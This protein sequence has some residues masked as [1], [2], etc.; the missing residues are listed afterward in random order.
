M[1][2]F[3]SLYNHLLETPYSNASAFLKNWNVAEPQES[4]FRLF[5][6]LGIVDELTDFNPCS[7]NFNMKTVRVVKTEADYRLLFQK[8]LRDK[9]DASDLTMIRGSEILATTSKN[10]KDYRVGDLDIDRIYCE[11][12]KYE[13]Y[14]LTLCIVIPDKKEFYK[15]VNRAEL[16]S[17]T[18]VEYCRRAIVLDHEDLNRYLATF[19]KEFAECKG[20]PDFYSERR[21]MKLYFHQQLAVDRFFE[22]DQPK[23]LLGCVPRSGKS[24]IVAGIIAKLNQ[25]DFMIMTTCPNETI[26]QYVEIFATYS[27]FR[28]FSVHILNKTKPKLGPKNIFICSQQYMK[29]E[30]TGRIKNIKWLASRQL[31]IIFS[32]EA[33]NGGTT[34]TSGKILEKYGNGKIMYITATY[35]KPVQ[36]FDIP[37]NAQILW[38]L[39]DIRLCKTNPNKL[40]EK[41][42]A[43]PTNP[44]EYAKYPDF[45]IMTV[46]FEKAIE[47]ELQKESV[48]GWSTKGVFLLKQNYKNTIGEFQDPD[49]VKALCYSIFG[50]RGIMSRIRNIVNNPE[51]NSRWF[52]KEQPLIVMC[53][54]PSNGNI[55]L[56]MKTFKRFL[57]EV[58][59]EFEIDY[60]NSKRSADPLKVIEDAYAL[61]K[62]NRKKGLIVLSGTQCSLGVSIHNC[63]IVLNLNNSKSFDQYMQMGFRGMTEAPGKRC[64][65]LVDL[66]VQR[67]VNLIV[68]EGLRMYSNESVGGCIKKMLM[69]RVIHFNADELYDHFEARDSSRKIEQLAGKLLDLYN[70]GPH[71]SIDK[72]LDSLV[73]KHAIFQAE[74]YKL[75]NSLFTTGRPPTMIKSIAE[76]VLAN[77]ISEGIEKRTVE[78]TKPEK[79]EDKK[80]NFMRDVMRHV[81]PL[82]SILTIGT[83]EYSFVEMLRHIELDD[84]LSVIFIDQLQQWWGNKISKEV[85]YI[86]IRVYNTYMADDEDISLI[87]KRVKELFVL[88]K[89]NKRKLSQ[90]IDK[91]LIPQ[92]MEKKKNAEVSTPFKLRQEMLSAITTHGDP[93]FWRTPKKVFEPCAGKGG[94]LIDIVDRFLDGGLDYKTI[95]EE[96]LYFA[97]INPTNVFICRLLLDP[98]EE[99]ALNCYQGDTLKLDIQK[100]WG[101][102]GFDAVVGNPPYNSSGSIATGNTIW[103]HFV[104]RSL[105]EW[106]TKG[107]YVNMVHP[108]GWRKPNTKKGKFYGLY[109]LMCRQNA[110]LYLSIHG[111]KDGQNTFKCG[112]RYDWYLIKNGYETGTTRVN[113]EKGDEID[114]N[115]VDFNW[116]PNYN[117][118]FIQ[119]ILAQKGDDRCPIVY[120]RTA[121]G[122]DKKQWMSAKETDEFKYPCVHSTPKNG[123]R[124]MFS[125]VNDRGHFGVSKIIFGESGISGVIIDM[126]GE[127]GM[128][129]GAMYIKIDDVDEGKQ[130]AQALMSDRFQDIIKSCN[131]SSFRID[132]NIFKDMRKDFWREFV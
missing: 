118:D 4:L 49:A 131:Y 37:T 48:Y 36:V 40:F 56:L 87:V 19:Y 25:G 110:M 90:N 14:T 35:T 121:Y 64:G 57:E 10:L 3:E 60:I 13:G 61:T 94:F 53:F 2:T 129:H 12:N 9:G 15:I 11:F 8:S 33:H 41:H 24:Y 117:I 112:T 79:K 7:G 50:K 43:A 96:C 44:T 52:S 100:E 74:E 17:A 39:E 29:T 102:S 124:Y 126:K 67:V 78:I 83:K 130:I 21:R 1:T 89:D 32:D 76:A 59:P 115:V 86:F 99:Y 107:G 20:L 123:T 104:K 5:V 125:K 84:R 23:V 105:N 97:D 113:D 93:N 119:K 55:D 85:I 128:T 47:A 103:Q 66:N 70:K 30:K 109:E 73:L 111:I 28:E 69:S 82:I 80:I 42:G 88:S 26:D 38:D 71:S 65:F 31:S 62:N 81:I 68:A 116:L 45:H 98:H 75:F 132:W 106:T 101:L 114:I 92:D 6:F 77:D 108:P 34:E 72:I 27:E 18:M 51:Y 54:L 58:V 16:T 22:I 120:D 127:Y 95:V 46:R 91:Y 63:D 122:A